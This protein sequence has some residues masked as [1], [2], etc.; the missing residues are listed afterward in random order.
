MKING[1]ITGDVINSTSVPLGLRKDLLDALTGVMDDIK[2]VVGLRYEVFRGDSIQVVV[3]NP[4]ESMLVA[5]LMKAGL[6][7]R[8]PQSEGSLWD[9]R[10]AVGVGKVEF[11]ADGVAMSDGE[12]FRLSGRGLD[13][14]G[15]ATVALATPWTDVNAEFAVSLPFVDDVIENWTVGQSAQMFQALL[16][17]I[18]QKD[19]ARQFGVSA[20]TVSRTL[21]LAREKP[22]RSFLERFNTVI[23][24][25][26]EEGVCL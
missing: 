5:L 8:T 20:Q 24:N 3:E 15:K 2:K 23:T 16:H 19:M 7:S 10:V 12:A 26:V 18:P 25:K 14:I 1:V 17:N 9:M 11:L 4:A 6:R 13:A 22:V 21:I